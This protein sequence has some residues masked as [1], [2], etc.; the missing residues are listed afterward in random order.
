MDAAIGVVLFVP[1]LG[2]S[3]LRSKADIADLHSDVR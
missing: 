1:T 3:A 2:M